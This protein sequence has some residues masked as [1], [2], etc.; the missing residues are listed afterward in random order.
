M[1]D[2]VE[3]DGHAG[4]GD[5]GDVHGIDHGAAPS[6][7]TEVP[8]ALVGEKGGPGT[9]VAGFGFAQEDAVHLVGG[10]DEAR[11]DFLNGIRGILNADEPPTFVADFETA[12]DIK[13]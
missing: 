10:G 7:P 13:D 9:A 3:K 1:L 11:D 8:R 2:E 4:D 6:L 5:A 12:T